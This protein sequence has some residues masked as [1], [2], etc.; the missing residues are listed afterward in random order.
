MTRTT[1]FEIV[2]GT[3]VVAPDSPHLITPYVL[4]EQH[5]WFEDEIGF[6]RHLLLPGER[7]VDVGANYGL[8]TLSMAKAVGPTEA[9][10]AFEPAS[11]TSEFLE[12]SIV[13]NNFPQVVLERS[14]LSCDRGTAQLTLN[15]NCELNAL[16]R[17]EGS[18]RTSETVRLV[19]LDDCLQRH[20]WKQID[21]LKIDAEGEEASMVE[22][23]RRFFTEQSPLILFEV[24]AVADV[25]VD[26]VGKFASLGF[27]SY[28][29]V[30]GLD[31]LVPFD[32]ATKPDG[33]LLNL[34]CCKRIEQIYCRTEACFSILPRLHPTKRQIDSTISLKNI[35]IRTNGKSSW[36]R[37]LT[38]PHLP[39]FGER[40]PART[41]RLPTPWRVSQ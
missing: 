26:L 38:E 32:A 12:Q 3:R 24:K 30:P 40:F 27:D 17:G 5:D 36:W 11:S 33:Y 34:F 18:D 8:Y 22:G 13:A 9:V 4:V 37:C 23:G 7:A 16:V 39:I 6:L 10:W 19:T 15:D 2:D 41:R 35:V 28:R 21:L 25:H 31:M 14:A 20:G 1:V 29:L